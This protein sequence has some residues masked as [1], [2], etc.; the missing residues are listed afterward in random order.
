MTRKSSKHPYATHG[1]LNSCF[2]LIGSHQQC[3][4]VFTIPSARAGCD[5]RSIWKWSLTV[6]GCYTKDKKKLSSLLFQRENNWIH[7]FPKSIR[8]M[9]NAID[10]V[11]DLNSCHRVRFLRWWP[12]HD[13]VSSWC[14]G[15]SDEQRNR[16]TRVRTFKKM[17]LDTSLLNTQYYKVRIKGKMEQSRERRSALPYTLNWI[18]VAIEKGCWTK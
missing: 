7:T 4:L 9:W 18:V 5:T 2:D 6:T 1:T 15:S 3:I 16:S 12:L 11:Q 8:A 10:L 17:L 13:G 14:N